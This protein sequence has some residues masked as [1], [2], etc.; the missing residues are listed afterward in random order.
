ML[1]IGNPLMEF[2]TDFNS[3]D[4]YYWS[5]GMISDHTYKLRT[6]VCNTST[7]ARQAMKGSLTREC[8]G[9]E[10]ETMD[11]YSGLY[12]YID[13]YYVI[14]DNC[15]SYN[16]SQAAILG[17]HLRPSMSQIS[18]SLNLQKDKINTPQVKY[19]IKA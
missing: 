5:H 6:S 18:R 12:N 7:V 15:L 11:E 19:M 1:Q 9:V 16:L 14:G 17:P 2:G 10:L 3:I 8:L 13:P 4:E